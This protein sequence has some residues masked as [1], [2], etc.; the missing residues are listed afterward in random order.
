MALGDSPVHF[1]WNTAHACHS[2][3][4]CCLF[5]YFHSVCAISRT[6]RLEQTQNGDYQRGIPR[7]DITGR[8]RRVQMFAVKVHSA[9]SS[10]LI[11]WLRQLLWLTVSACQRPAHGT[12]KFHYP[13]LCDREEETTMPCCHEAR[14]GGRIMSQNGGE[15]KTKNCHSSNTHL[16]L[17]DSSHAYFKSSTGSLLCCSVGI[18][19]V[20]PWTDLAS[21]WYLLFSPPRN[22]YWSFLKLFLYTVVSV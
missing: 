12:K 19:A 7:K 1:S 13:H 16:N 9:Y 2:L 11:L 20:E 17:V 22:Y 8:R 21:F 3:C 15:K 5:V 18:R 4:N 10:L 6:R 14:K